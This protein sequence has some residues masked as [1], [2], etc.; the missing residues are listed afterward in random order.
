MD[1]TGAG[2]RGVLGCR[3]WLNI[4]DVCAH[5]LG[6]RKAQDAEQVT[7]GDDAE[8]VEGIVDSRGAGRRMLAKMGAL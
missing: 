3:R 1:R 8:G 7:D 5:D 6:Y 2:R 4:V